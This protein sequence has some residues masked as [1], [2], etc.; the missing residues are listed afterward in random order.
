MK[1]MHA[2]AW[3]FKN[4]FIIINEKF[5]ILKIIDKLPVF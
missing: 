2:Y 3:N 4:H 5:Y 1:Y